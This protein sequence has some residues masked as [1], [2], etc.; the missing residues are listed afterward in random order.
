MVIKKADL[1]WALL[2]ISTS[3]SLRQLPNNDTTFYIA[4]SRKIYYNKQALSYFSEKGRQSRDICVKV[5]ERR[6]VAFWMK[7][8]IQIA[9]KLR[10]V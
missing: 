6:G 9:L 2:F 10:F 7:E 4:F 5:P 8:R 3:D 1:I